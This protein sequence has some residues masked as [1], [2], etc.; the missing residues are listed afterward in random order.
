[1][2]DDAT[3]PLIHRIGNLESLYACEECG[4][5]F[6]PLRAKQKRCGKKECLL[7]AQ[8]RME[9]ERR[10]RKWPSSTI[11]CHA[12]QRVVERVSAT[13]I[14]CHDNACQVRAN[15]L[16]HKRNNIEQQHKQRARFAEW[17]A[18]KTG[19][20]NV[21]SPWLLGA[22][23][24]APRLPGGLC[25][26]TITPAPRWPIELRNA[27]VFHGCITSI[28]AQPHTKHMAD[29]A[30]IAGTQWGVY[31][32]SDAT[33]EA[34]ANRMHE[35]NIFGRSVNVG[36]GPLRHL[37]TPVVSK[38]GRRKLTFETITPVAM[39]RK[40]AVQPLEYRDY[41]TPSSDNIKFALCGSFV[42]KL[43]IKLPME[44]VCMT[45]ISHVTEPVVI[46][47]GGKYGDVTA[48][49]GR[50]VVE[51]NAVGEWLLRCAEMIGF[52]GR[53]AFGFGQIKIV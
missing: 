22:P 51:T 41:D 43:G 48:W 44:T 3:Q 33:A 2:R 30:L 37:Q 32:R 6:I 19:G 21:K 15:W 49:Q 26:I 46:Q 20:T 42:G 45:L 12:C 1:M 10:R 39:R 9:R 53:T 25:S 23:L 18:K 52:A 14:T 8:A 11:T 27:R 17:Y 5:A 40:I 28:T 36:F 38:R 13:Q 47:M 31:I 29:F 16:L 35:A 4:L 34:V 24:Y 7:A 50:C